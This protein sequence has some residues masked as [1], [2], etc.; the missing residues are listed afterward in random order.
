[1][2]N[3]AVACGSGLACGGSRSSTAPVSTRSGFNVSVMILLLLLDHLLQR[4]RH[5]TDRL[6]DELHAAIGGLPNDDVEFAAGRI[7]LGIVLAKVAA[8]AF[9]PLDGGPGDGLGDRQQILEVECRV[10]ARIVLPITADTYLP[11]TRPE[12]LDVV[13]RLLHFRLAPHD[14]DQLLHHGLELLLHLVSPA[15]IGG[16]AA[17]EWCQGGMSGLIDLGG[18]ERSE[19]M[20]PGERRCVIAG[21]LAEDQQIREGIT[22][23]PVGSVQARRTFTCRKQPRQRRHLAIA[24]DPNAT[25][26]VVGGRSHFHRRG[27]DVDVGELLELMVH[28]RELLDDVPGGIGKLLPDPGDVEKHASVG[29]ASTFANLAH[30]AAGDVIASEQLGWS[31]S[32]LV[33]LRVAPALFLIVGSLA[34][35]IL[36]NIVEHEA[37]AL[38]VEQD[39]AFAPYALGHEDAANARWPDHARRMELH[40]LHVLQRSADLVRESMAVAGVLPTVARNGVGPA[41]AAGC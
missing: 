17:L 6:A 15:P 13:E 41:D 34:A 23:Q 10:P 5:C 26:D 31:P 30:D 11:C 14:A 1:M 27:G 4:R 7:L 39:A 25:H 33:A 20:L 24:V 22:A 3:V 37:T 2:R 32:V 18:V 12:A 16:R 19:A 8:P 38:V 36:R 29:A 21:A 9:L 40:E 35:I 28:A